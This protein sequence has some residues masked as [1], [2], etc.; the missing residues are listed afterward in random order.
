MNNFL[1][2]NYHVISSFLG[3]TP[4]ILIFLLYYFNRK[5]QSPTKDLIMILVGWLIIFLS[6]QLLW[7]YLSLY[8]PQSEREDILLSD[9]APRAFSLIFG[10]VYALLLLGL[11][12][13][14]D[15]TIQW[16]KK[17]IN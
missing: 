4:I 17:K 14:S 13:I 11:F 6:T 9:G 1:Y 12:R 7:N 15:R 10:W 8:S 2:S 5:K 3:F 16:L